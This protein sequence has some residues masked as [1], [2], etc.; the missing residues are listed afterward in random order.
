MKS[1]PWTDLPQLF[2][3]E[4]AF[5]Q[6]LR[7][8]SRE[9][10]KKHPI[11]TE[12]IKQKRKKLPV[13]KKTKANPEG[14]VW[15]C[16]CEICGKVTRNPQTDHIESCGSTGS[17]QEWLVWLEKLLILGFE[18]IQLLCKDCH[19]VKSYQ[20]R[21]GLDYNAAKLRKKEIAFEKSD[22]KT[23]TE[24]LL[25]AGI[26]PAKTKKARLEQ[27]ANLLGDICIK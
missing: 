12:Y 3:D 26:Q 13:G 19:D 5:C 24:I 11:R 1:N 8:A 18:D 17:I 7:S 15:A 25:A 9:I 4:K 2:K 21:T 22:S 6:W 20:D 23:Q 27:Y 16:N 10:W 14:I